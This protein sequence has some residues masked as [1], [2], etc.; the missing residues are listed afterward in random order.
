MI[1]RDQN[2]GRVAERMT[3][4]TLHGVPFSAIYDPSGE[5]LVD[6]AG[7]LGNVGFPSGFEGKKQ[8]REMLLKSRTKL[9]DSEID[10]LVESIES[11]TRDAG[12]R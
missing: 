4:G 5:R 11:P 8:L 6:S 7:P 12:D 2:G 1:F 9:T 10:S 3:R